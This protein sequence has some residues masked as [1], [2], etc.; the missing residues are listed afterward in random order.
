MY[1]SLAHCFELKYGT[2]YQFYF[3][4]CA[5]SNLRNKRYLHVFQKYTINY[6]HKM[7]DMEQN[8]ARTGLY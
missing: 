8:L 5:V 4:F 3:H 6:I 7:H 1:R 2:E